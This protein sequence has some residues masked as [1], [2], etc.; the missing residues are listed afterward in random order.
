MNYL[1]LVLTCF[2][3]F[4]LSP[5]LPL[6][7][8]L[9]FSQFL[10]IHTSFHLHLCVSPIH[11]CIHVC[12]HKLTPPPHSCSSHWWAGLLH[13]PWCTTLTRAGTPGWSVPSLTVRLCWYIHIHIHLLFASFWGLC[14]LFISCACCVSQ[15]LLQTSTSLCCLYTSMYVLHTNTQTG[16]YAFGFVLM[17]PQLFINYRMKSVAHMPW[18]VLMY[19]VCTYIHTHTW[20]VYSVF[21]MACNVSHVS[22]GV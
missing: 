19:K 5:F 4:S 3:R 12:T 11:T 9:A 7:L 14:V 1:S 21:L 20:S 22:V 18:R 8:H 17:T 16:V 6:P 2:L 10:S 15:F 13:T